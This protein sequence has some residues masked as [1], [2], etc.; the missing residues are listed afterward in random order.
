MAKAILRGKAFARQ[1][2]GAVSRE[3]V[4]DPKIEAGRDILGRATMGEV[5]TVGRD[6]RKP[7]V[8]ARIVVPVTICCGACPRCQ[9]GNGSYCGTPSDARASRH[10]R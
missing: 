10:I 7:K 6:D 3:T 2:R 1:S 4:P 5:I 9:W 8:G